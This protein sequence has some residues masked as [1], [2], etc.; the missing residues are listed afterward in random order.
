MGCGGSKISAVDADALDGDENANQSPVNG[1]KVASN[2]ET[3]QK[4][5]QF[6]PEI[7]TNGVSPVEGKHL[8][9]NIMIFN[10]KYT[11]RRHI[12]G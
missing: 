1:I 3:E 8:D 11:I 6:S 2:E 10:C 5:V 7:K 9:L 4:S 12:V